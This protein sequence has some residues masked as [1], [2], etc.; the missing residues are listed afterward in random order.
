MDEIKADPH[1]YRGKGAN[2]FMMNQVVTFVYSRQ[3]TIMVSKG[4][5]FNSTEKGIYYSAIEKTI[6]KGEMAT[7]TISGHEGIQEFMF[8]PFDPKTKYSVTV[9]NVKAKLINDGI[10]YINLGRVGKNDI[11]SFS[12]SLDKSNVTAFESFVI[13]NYN[14]Q[15]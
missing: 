2:R 10:S 12:I 4:D 1:E 14:P 15:K 13:L 6:K 8:I 11:I 3:N 7:Y 9:N 5:F